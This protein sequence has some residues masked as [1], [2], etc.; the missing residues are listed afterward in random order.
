MISH[1]LHNARAKYW[2]AVDNFK[3]AVKYATPCPHC[4]MSASGGDSS[5]L[6][7]NLLSLIHSIEEIIDAI[8]TNKKDLKNENKNH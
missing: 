2:L 4:G 1:R 8:K 5:Y 7:E 6:R 3:Q